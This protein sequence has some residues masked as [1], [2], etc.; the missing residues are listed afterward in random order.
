VVDPLRVC[1]CTPEAVPFA[2]TGGLADVAGALPPALAE[3]GCDVRVILP[4]YRAIDRRRFGFRGMGGATVPL[5]P[6]HVDVRFLESRLPGTRVPVYLVA[7]APLFDRPGLYGE[8]GRDYEDNLERFT[9]FCRGALALVRHLGWQPDV[10]HVQDWQTALIPVWLRL[11]PRDPGTARTGTLLTVHN[12]AYQGLFPADRLPATGLPP[13]TFTPRGLEFYGKINLLKGGLI[14]ADR[15]ST[16]SEQ[17]AREIQTPEFGCGLEGVLQERAA[18]LIGILNGVDYAAWDPRTDRHIAAPYTRDDLSGKQVCKAHLQ[19]AQGLAQ[20]P[21]APLLGIV[22]R[23][24]DQKGLDLI[25]ATVDVLLGFGAHLVLLGTGDPKYHAL[26]SALAERFPRRVSVTLGFDDSLAHRIEAG[27]DIFLMP[28]RYEPSGLNQLYSLRYGTIPVVRKTGGLAD[29][30]VDAT[31]EAIARGAATGFV[32]EA[33][34]PDAF[35]QAVTRALAAFRDPELWR[36]LQQT[37][38]GQDFSWTRS[39]ARYIETYRR[40]AARPGIGTRT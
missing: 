35:L 26:F 17:Y 12:L 38:M 21:Q 18:D 32:F 16:V 10:V 14:Y 36:R 34:T 9:A 1:F 15:V 19:R 30:I 24:V 20:D 22:S 13:E 28:S 4:G 39:A 23:L 29:S 11:E 31:P 37:G 5:G 8:E 27:A 25:A 2:K 33:Y 40:I 7:S 6:S 3:G